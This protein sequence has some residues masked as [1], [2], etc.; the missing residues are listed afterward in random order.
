VRTALI[1]FHGCLADFLPPTRRDSRFALSFE[2]PSGLRD[3]VQS[4]GVPHV[5]VE[6]VM[7]DGEPSGWR[8]VIHG[9]EMIDV[10]PR[11]P[12]DQA[13]ADA[14]FVLDV[15]LGRLARN[16]RLLGFD[17]RQDP[18]ADDPDL[19]VES[20]SD[21]RTLLTRDRGLL[22]RGDLTN[23]TYIRATE[24]VVQTVETIARFRVGGSLNPFTRCLVCNAVLI[25]EDPTHPDIPPAVRSGHDRFRR[26]PGCGRVY[27]EGSH[28]ERLR[29]LVAEIE[30][31]VAG[32]P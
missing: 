26:C 21:G 3:L 4:T 12:L 7:V 8:R 19:V 18:S 31:R 32:L 13:P 16:L 14:R 10:Y 2:L 27:W 29:N 25:E 6:R 22:M 9:D 5:E 28:V 20:Q 30:D 11:Y 1:R 23:A 15:H 24:P 17:A